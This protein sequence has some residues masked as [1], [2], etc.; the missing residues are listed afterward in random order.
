M[1]VSFFRAVLPYAQVINVAHYELD[2]LLGCSV[3][4]L[5]ALVKP[6]S[7]D[8]CEHYARAIL[9]RIGGPSFEQLMIRIIHTAA[10]KDG[11]RSPSDPDAYYFAVRELFP[12]VAEA[13]DVV[14]RLVL[15]T[16]LAGTLRLQG[17]PNLM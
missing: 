3:D 7:A 2:Q 8:N 4:E 16:M 9:G 17:Q 10:P 1:A 5:I 14:G 6:M 15:L 13:S 12:H 11:G